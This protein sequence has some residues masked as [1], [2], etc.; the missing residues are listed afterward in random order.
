MSLWNSFRRLPSRLLKWLR[1]RKFQWYSA[2]LRSLSLPS[3]AR[4]ATVS[5]CVRSV[6]DSRLR[7]NGII[8]YEMGCDTV[9]L[10]RADALSAMTGGMLETLLDR[11]LY[12]GRKA[13]PNEAWHDLR[14]VALRLAQQIEQLRSQYPAR[15]I[16]LSP[17]HYVSQY[18]CAYVV[19]EV[20][21]A[22][23]L[24]SL[25]VVSGVPQDRYGVDATVM[26]HLVPLHTGETVGRN[27]LGLK[28]VRALR[29]DRVVVLFADLP[30]YTMRKFPMETVGVS[31]LGRPSRIHRGAFSI[32]AHMDALLLPFYLKFSHG[33]FDAH[34]FDAIS[35]ASSEAPQ[36]VADCISSAL[37]S[38][39]P[40]W[41]MAG[42]PPMYG[43]ACA[44]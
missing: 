32:G 24:D 16:I 1:Y 25:S 11:R 6:F 8:R 39:Y 15:P 36:Q 30:P 14:E 43:F 26:P 10:T 42:Y 9:S 38:N 17:F 23:R 41:L 27:S 19:D 35:L 20:R 13:R 3:V 22:L 2:W 29:H 28:V 44:K 40:H 37:T 5:W 21:K 4:W 31:I 7:W 34:V 33:R 12:L 18:A